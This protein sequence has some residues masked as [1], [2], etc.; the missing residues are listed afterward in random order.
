M[1]ATRLHALLLASLTA[2]AFPA[3]AADE[4]PAA[5]TAPTY[6]CHESDR[7]PLLLGTVDAGAIL[8]A[9]PDWPE[10]LE[11]W[12]PDAAAITALRQVAS[13]TDILCV[14]GTWCGDSQREVPRFWRLLEITANPNLRFTM[15]AVGRSTDAAAEQALAGL[16]LGA[17]YR[18]DHRTEKIPTFIFSSEGREIGRIVET[19]QVSL[20]ADALTILESAG[21]KPRR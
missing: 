5:D 12:L 7:G 3:G 20:E 14:L 8:A 19:P 15:V 10:D 11:D 17:S 18:A 2:F 9:F 21:L 1:A 6:L 16:G 13:S 4:T